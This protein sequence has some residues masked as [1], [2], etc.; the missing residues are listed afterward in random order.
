MGLGCRGDGDRRLPVRHAWRLNWAK[1]VESQ[2]E[3]EKR[4]KV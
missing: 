3:K 4:G 2:D 1:E